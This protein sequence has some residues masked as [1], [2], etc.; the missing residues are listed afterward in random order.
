MTG[1]PVPRRRVSEYP[2]PLA[3]RQELW[4]QTWE[5][6]F[7]SI[8]RRAREAAERSAAPAEPAPAAIGPPAPPGAGH[9]EAEQI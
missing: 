5:D 2:L 4:R 1:E 7:T 9:R 6:L 3:V 8:E